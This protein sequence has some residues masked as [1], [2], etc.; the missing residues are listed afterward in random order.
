MVAMR[1]ILIH[2]YILILLIAEQVAFCAS[3]STS[4]RYGDFKHDD[5][6]KDIIFTDDVVASAITASRIR[7]LALCVEESCRYVSYASQSKQCYIY[8]QGLTPG[9]AQQ[10]SRDGAKFYTN[11]VQ[12]SCEKTKTGKVPSTSE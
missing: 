7:C 8:T 10:Y 6:F 9:T 4:F 5:T 1:A 12:P 11:K 3:D 2:G